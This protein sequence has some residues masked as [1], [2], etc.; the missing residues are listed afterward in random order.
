MRRVKGESVVGQRL[1]RVR[2]GKARRL[3]RRWGH[4]WLRLWVCSGRVDVVREGTG[5]VMVWI[6]VRKVMG[7]RGG[8]ERKRV[9]L[10]D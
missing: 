8:Q 3:R 6:R 7:L 5:E 4:C 9:E 10:A 1:E 2:V